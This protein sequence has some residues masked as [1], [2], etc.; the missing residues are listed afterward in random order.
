MVYDT[1]S[2]RTT[3]PNKS[4]GIIVS[5]RCF[6]YCRQSS[7]SEGASE[8]LS[9]NQQLENCL[10]CAKSYGL[11]ITGV[12]TD[13]NVSGKT[14]PAGYEQIAAADRGFQQ[15]YAGQSGRKQFRSGLGELLKRLPEVQVIVVDEITRLYRA[16]AGSFL[17][18]ILYFA[19]TEKRIR[20]LQVKGGW[21]DL[22][23][24]D[25]SLIQLLRTRINDEQ[26]NHQ[27]K[28]SMESRKRLRDDG[29]VC[30]ANFYAGIYDGHKHFHF[31]PEKGECVRQIFQ[32]V[33][34][35]MSLGQLCRELNRKSRSVIY[36][37]TIRRI[38]TNRIYTGYMTDSNGLLIPC[39]NLAEPLI[40]VELF[41][42]VR[43]RLEDQRERNIKSR[44]ETCRKYF[45]P[46]SGYLKC[47]ICGASL[48]CE[49]DRGKIFYQ[50]RNSVLGRNKRCAAVR[51]LDSYADGRKIN[52]LRHTLEPFFLFAYRKREAQLRAL[53]CNEENRR[54][55]EQQNRCL[56]EQLTAAF[57]ACCADLVD[58]TDLLALTSRQISQI[59]MLRLQLYQLT[60]YDRV[61]TETALAELERKKKRFLTDHKIDHIEYR[62]LI[63]KCIDTVYVFP[64]YIKI[65]S[66]PP[67]QMTVS[68]P[69]ILCPR[70]QRLLPDWKIR[71]LKNGTAKIFYDI[72][73]STPRTVIFTTKIQ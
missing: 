28:K 16:A 35:G 18:Q 56:Q 37:S 70:Q 63:S 21:L 67:E 33:A 30:N 10:N 24:F 50:C 22:S 11:D 60:E 51:I 14:Y 64:E 17:E 13:A 71:H 20:I 26:I 49:F 25:Q 44:T 5:E 7:G 55:L 34:S 73:G 41:E 32:A 48:Q 69:R 62:Q 54:Q 57:D 27:R 15:W 19:L 31:D 53:I 6:V 68:L 23:S 65:V 36:P 47:G 12:F 66:A 3:E 40:S 46:L 43:Q 8:S 72:P 45:L 2:V 4:G 29:Y 52:G 58:K 38:L 39:R 61:E 9:I 59:N 42:E 1:A